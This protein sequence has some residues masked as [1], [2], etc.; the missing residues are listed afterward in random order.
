M[1]YVGKMSLGVFAV[2]TIEGNQQY[3]VFLIRPIASIEAEKQ[4]FE[5]N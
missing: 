4:V 5:I 1:T 3:F 2:S